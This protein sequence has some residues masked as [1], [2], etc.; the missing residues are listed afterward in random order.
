MMSWFSAAGLVVTRISEPRAMPVAGM[1][2]KDV[3]ERV[4]Y[5]SDAWEEL[6][7]QL[8]HIPMMIIFVAEKR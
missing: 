4:P 3:L 7:D 6:Y 2:E 8:A 5:Y 1:T